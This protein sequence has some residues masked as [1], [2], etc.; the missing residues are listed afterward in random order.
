MEPGEYTSSEEAKMRDGRRS[1]THSMPAVSAPGLTRRLSAAGPGSWPR[2]LRRWRCF[3]APSDAGGSGV[4]ESLVWRPSVSVQS[5]WSLHVSRLALCFSG[6]T[7]T[8]TP[9]LIVDGAMWSVTRE[10]E[11]LPPACHHGNRSS[12]L[13]FRKADGMCWK[14]TLLELFLPQ[15]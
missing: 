15:R 6:L 7:P 4:Q 11:S 14:Y 9:L 13:L 10:P 2:V 8:L 5:T 3:G 1:A 12:P